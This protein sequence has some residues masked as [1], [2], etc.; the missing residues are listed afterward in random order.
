MIP[1]QHYELGLALANE[2]PFPTTTKIALS[3]THA[4][5]QQSHHALKPKLSPQMEQLGRFRNWMAVALHILQKISFMR[6]EG[7]K[8]ETLFELSERRRKLAYDIDSAW[9]AFIAEDCCAL[10]RKVNEFLHDLD[11]F[12]MHPMIVAKY[13]EYQLEFYDHAA[14]QVAQIEAD[15]IGENRQKYV[16]HV[17]TLNFW[18]ETMKKARQRLG[19]SLTK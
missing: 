9:G 17:A 11:H 8:K 3:A 1:R 4:A 10:L 7:Y 13:E 14:I 16:D 19:A 6:E 18:I 5:I 15:Y 2:E 12:T